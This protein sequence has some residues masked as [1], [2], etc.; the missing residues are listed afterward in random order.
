MIDHIAIRK[1]LK[2]ALTQSIP[3]SHAG[4]VPVI[5]EVTRNRT[6]FPQTFWTN[7]YKDSNSP[8]QGTSGKNTFTIFRS[9]WK[10]IFFPIYIFSTFNRN[11]WKS[12]LPAIP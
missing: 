11:V 5:K 3:H 10:T 6:T 4:Q 2:K 8:H 12:T 1:E 7:P 9:I